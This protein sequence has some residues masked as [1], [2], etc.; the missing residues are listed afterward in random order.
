M[1]TL[2]GESDGAAPSNAVVGLLQGLALDH[3]I[4]G[5]YAEV[6]A[7][8]AQKIL[9]GRDI[10]DMQHAEGV[11]TRLS[12]LVRPTNDGRVS[13]AELFILVSAAFLHDIGKPAEHLRTNGSGLDHGELSAQMIVERCDFQLLFPCNPLQERVAATVSVHNLSPASIA[14]LEPEDPLDP[15]SLGYLRIADTRVRPRL[16]AALLMLADD[17][18]CSCERT[19][20]LKPDDPRNCISDVQVSAEQGRIWYRFRYGTDA[21]KK[22]ACEK[23]LRDI[24]S[25]LAPYLAPYR[26]TFQYG[27][28]ER[29]WKGPTAP[30]SPPP[31]GTFG[32]V[33]RLVNEMLR[34]KAEQAKTLIPPM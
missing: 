24:L 6:I 23:R 18:E 5:A 1:K 7:C 34:T 8:T 12:Q 13:I 11:H 15:V 21:E 2:G 25:N 30:T 10:N 19:R 9:R 31:I 33:G 22:E 26:F 28:L 29:E 27:R 20:W 32:R 4:L 3:P 14:Q 17:L 16:L